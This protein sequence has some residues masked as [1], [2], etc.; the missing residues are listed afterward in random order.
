MSFNKKDKRRSS[1]RG[2]VSAE[3]S[4]LSENTMFGD[5]FQSR[6]T[7]STGLFYA[8]R[9]RYIHTNNSDLP[10]RPDISGRATTAPISGKSALEPPIDFMTMRQRKNLLRFERSGFHSAGF[11]RLEFKKLVEGEDRQHR[12]LHAKGSSQ[13]QSKTVTIQKYPSV[14][15]HDWTEEKQAG[16]NFYVHRRTGEACHEKPWEAIKQRQKSAD[17]ETKDEECLGT[18]SLVYDSTELN[19]LFRQ[20]DEEAEKERRVKPETM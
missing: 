17:K 3:A 9:R 16:C 6:A 8:G 15:R 13:N 1:S 12:G 20:L 4:T 19:D 14:S 2:N 10:S 5:L 11:Q 7:Y 18:G